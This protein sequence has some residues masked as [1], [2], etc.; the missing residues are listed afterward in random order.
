MAAI[1]SSSGITTS[2]GGIIN[3]SAAGGTGSYFIS[4]LAVSTNLDGTTAGSNLYYTSP[5]VGNFSA[6][7][8]GTWR[9]MGAHTDSAGGFQLWTR[10]S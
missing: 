6:G 5:G 1:L 3:S 9:W 8:S 4:Y 2:S 10:I 7:F